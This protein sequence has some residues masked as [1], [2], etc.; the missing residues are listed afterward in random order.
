MER[1]VKYLSPQ[2][3]IC[4]QPIE[5][6]KGLRVSKRAFD[7]AVKRLGSVYKNLNWKTEYSRFLYPIDGYTKWE[8]AP[9]GSLVCWKEGA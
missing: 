5:G 1:I 7:R 4:P 3:T 6:D 2:V 9:D 8:W